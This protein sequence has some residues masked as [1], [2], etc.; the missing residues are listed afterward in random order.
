MRVGGVR[1][2]THVSEELMTAGLFRPFGC[3]EV[4]LEGPS[5]PE[6]LGQSSGGGRNFGQSKRENVRAFRL[7]RSRKRPET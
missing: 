6:A 1:L 4:W 5:F 2:L 3:P 7:E